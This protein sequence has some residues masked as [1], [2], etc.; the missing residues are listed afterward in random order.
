MPNWPWWSGHG[1]R[2]LSRGYMPASACRPRI[3]SQVTLIGRPPACTV[4]GVAVAATV[5]AATF[6]PSPSISLSRSPHNS[7]HGP[8]Q[9]GNLPPGLNRLGREVHN[10]LCASQMGTVSSLAALHWSAIDGPGLPTC[11]LHKVV[12]YLEV[13]RTHQSGDRMAP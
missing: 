10:K 12:S 1:E 13:L 8:Q 6:G 4:P 9:R 7:S 11:V 5:I 3:V 2:R